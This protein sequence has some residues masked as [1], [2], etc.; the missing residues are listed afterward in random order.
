[1]SIDPEGVLNMRKLLAAALVGVALW[2]ASPAQA[3]WPEG[4]IRWANRNAKVVETLTTD[5]VCDQTLLPPPDNCVSTWRV[6][7][8]RRARHH[9]VRVRCVFTS[10]QLPSTTPEV[11]TL[12]FDTIVRRGQS[13]TMEVPWVSS[14]SDWAC[15]GRKVTS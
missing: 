4:T 10:F 12:G 2:T 1:V 7:V 8:K 13:W 9:D 6:Q 15:T 11:Q 14:T 3:A 5:D